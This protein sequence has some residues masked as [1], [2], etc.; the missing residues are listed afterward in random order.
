MTCKDFFGGKG[1]GCSLIDLPATAMQSGSEIAQNALN[2]APKFADG[3][4]GGLENITDFLKN[5]VS[6]IIVLIVAYFLLN[7]FLK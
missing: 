2:R 1:W 5:P 4:F 7:K 6:L 3:L